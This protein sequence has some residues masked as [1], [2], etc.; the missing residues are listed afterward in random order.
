VIAGEGEGGNSIQLIA[1]V[2]RLLPYLQK[3]IAHLERSAGVVDVAEVGDHVRFLVGNLPQHQFGGVLTCSPV[4][5]DGHLGF[6]RELAVDDK[7]AQVLI[8][9]VGN[10]FLLGDEILGVLCGSFRIA[11]IAVAKLGKLLFVSLL[12]GLVPHNLR[13]GEFKRRE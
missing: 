4:A 6:V 13:L 10:L 9:N 3:V 12:V 7:V 8:N 5:D 1:K 2:Q 11:G